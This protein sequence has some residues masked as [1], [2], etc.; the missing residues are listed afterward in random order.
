MFDKLKT[1]FETMGME[2]S[3]QGSYSS[4]EEYPSSFFTFW[5][6]DTPEGSY[7]DNKAHRAEWVWLVY[8]YT[9]D[10]SLIYSKMDEFIRLAK[11]AGFVVDGR[12]EDTKSD[13]PD[14]YGRVVMV[15]FVE[16]YE[17]MV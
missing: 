3:R 2:Y 17:D 14:Y 16:I 9:C 4:P 7:Y 8:F 5:N 1:I 11:E 13:R 10:P 12:G 6:T 15:R